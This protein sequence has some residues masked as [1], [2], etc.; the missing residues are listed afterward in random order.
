MMSI[1]VDL[2]S[3]IRKV[4]TYYDK[5]VQRTGNQCSRSRHIV[6]VLICDSFIIDTALL[7]S[8][9][10]LS[11]CRRRFEIGG[12]HGCDRICVVGDVGGVVA[13]RRDAVARQRVSADWA[14]LWRVR[15]VRGRAFTHAAAG[16]L[17]CSMVINYLPAYLHE[18]CTGQVYFESTFTFAKEGNV[19]TRR[20]SVCMSV[21]RITQNVVDEFWRNF[22]REVGGVTTN[23]W[24]DF[25]GDSDRGA[26]PFYHSEIKAIVPISLVTQAVVEEFLC[27]FF[28]A[29]GCLTSKKS[30]SGSRCRFRNF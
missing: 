9:L 28:R 6:N 29:V 23:N 25:G 27:Y 16:V 7:K 20:L 5:Q 2:N 8:I 24:I 22:L 14:R 13:R 1:F 18:V 19:F 10:S 30:L 26:D 4:E 3:F 12:R 21:L 11:C 17:Y 15:G